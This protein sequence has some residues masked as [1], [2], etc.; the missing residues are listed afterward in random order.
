MGIHHSSLLAE[1]EKKNHKPR[2]QLS[3]QNHCGG[4]ALTSVFF[5]LP[6]ILPPTVNLHVLVFSSVSLYGNPGE[7]LPNG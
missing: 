2:V 5:H 3:K 7:A 4:V 6:P 1:T